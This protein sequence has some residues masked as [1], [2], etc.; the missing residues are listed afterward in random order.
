M[1][2]K[3]RIVVVTGAAEGIGAA[4]ARGAHARGAKA[5]V[6][7]D[8]NG[9]G[10]SAVAKAIGGRAVSCDVASDVAVGQLIAD[11][12]K[13]EGPIGL[14]CS[15]AG[16]GGSKS[17]PGNAASPA[18]EVWQRAW[19]VN[20]MSHVYA[21]R[22]LLPLMIARG[23]GAFLNTISAAGLLNQIGSAVYATTKHAAVGFA[24]NIAIAHRDQG[25]RVGILCP[26]AVDT[27]LLREAGVGAQHVDGVITPDQCADA[28]FAGLAAGHFCILPHP[29]VATYMKAKTADYDRWIGGM[30]KLQ[31]TLAA[32]AQGKS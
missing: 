9:V 18:D 2:V 15:N 4:L 1:D 23:G 13:T 16:I 20:V 25:I 22:H 8:R 26:Q 17:D 7:A 6:V 30:A 21:A 10:A 11:V 24:E 28:A 27:T 5:V 14:F 32:A 12:E 19:A 29:Q 31:R 3:G